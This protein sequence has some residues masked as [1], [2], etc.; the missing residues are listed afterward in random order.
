MLYAPP[1]YSLATSL[2]PTSQNSTVQVQASWGGPLHSLLELGLCL[3]Y[4]QGCASC[5]GAGHSS[6]WSCPYSTHR[7]LLPEPSLISGELTSLS[8]AS[9][10]L[11]NKQELK[12]FIMAEFILQE[13]TCQRTPLIPDAAQYSR[14][15][16]SV[17]IVLL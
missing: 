2:K 9:T 10:S 4:Q 15:W 17:A 6:L 13:D 16:Q 1:K 3:V 7:A 14:L 8:F 5:L 11:P 12:S